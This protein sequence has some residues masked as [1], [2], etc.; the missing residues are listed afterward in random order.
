M[1]YMWD[2]GDF[3]PN[4]TDKNNPARLA[5]I[6]AYHRRVPSPT[7]V[8]SGVSDSPY[9]S[10]VRGRV[11]FIITDSRGE[12]SPKGATDN[13]SKV[14]FSDDQRNW[15]FDEMLAAETAGQAIVWVVTKP[16]I[17]AATAGADHWGGYTTERT[18][19]SNFITTNGL[20]GR[21]V[22]ISGDMHA[23]AYDDGT[24]VNNIPGVKVI[25]A[26][27]LDREGSSKGGPYKVGPVR[28]PAS[29]DV[30]QYGLIDIADTGTGNIG[31]RFRGIS[32]NR[33][34]GVEAFEIDE[35]FN[36]ETGT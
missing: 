23:L 28:S 34:T 9:F 21:I 20:I 18:T 17:A 30:S 2:D 25:Q 36:L 7:L 1:Y 14:V 15:L 3:G 31:V 16:F 11:R 32:V 6:A 13:A 33:S 19:I 35:S 26:A 24:S 29:G 12:R 8:N 22:I 27:A 10:F 5:A 4:D